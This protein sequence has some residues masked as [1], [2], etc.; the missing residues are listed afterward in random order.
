MARIWVKGYTKSD[1]T[2]VPGHYRDISTSR[3]GSIY[4]KETARL[5]RQKKSYRYNSKTGYDTITSPAYVRIKKR[6]KR[7]FK[8]LGL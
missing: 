8:K 3:A 4:N 6:N 1:G 2:K 7:I 5:S